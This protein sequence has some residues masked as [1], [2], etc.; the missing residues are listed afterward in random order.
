ME[1]HYVCSEC[2]SVSKLVG[3]CQNENC[4]RLGVKLKE[5]HCED[6]KH[7]GIL[8]PWK[9]AEPVDDPE[10]AEEDEV[11]TPSDNVLDLDNMSESDNN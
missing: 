10:K 3:T 11:A 2:G 5:C 6:G 8:A 4:L 1:K 9:N 7:I